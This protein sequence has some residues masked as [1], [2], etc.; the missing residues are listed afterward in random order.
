MVKMRF[1]ANMSHEFRTSM[2]GVVQT[3]EVVRRTAI[4][5]TQKLV[6]RAIESSN[7]FLGTINSILDYTR[8]SQDGVRISMSSVGL[9]VLV[10]RVVGRH[11]AEISRRARTVRP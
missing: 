7:A 8:W 6:A 2:S 10:R 11:A 5:E 3:L 1:L 4:G 9:T